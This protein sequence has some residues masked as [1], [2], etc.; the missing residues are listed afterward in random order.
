MDVTVVVVD[1]VGDLGLAS[2]LEVFNT[3]NGLVDDL[4]VDPE[5]WH[6]HTVGVGTSVRSGHGHLVP[7]VPLSRAPTDIG[8]IIL[9][10]VLAAD[11]DAVLDLVDTP[12]NQPVLESISRAAAN[13]SQLSAACT[14][15]FFLAEA[16]ALDGICATTSWWLA[17]AFRR[18]YPKVDLDEGRILC[19]SGHIVTAGAALAHL[20][21]ALSI[22]AT[23]SPAQAERTA[24]ML[25]A[26]S[27]G[28]QRE[29]IVPQVVARGNPLVAAFERWV[30]D[31]IAQQFHIADVARELGVTVRSLQRATHAEIGMSPRDFVNEIRLERAT[32][33][34]RTTTLT[35][36]TVA[37]RVGYLNAGTLRGLYRRRRGRTIAE[38]RSSPLSWEDSATRTRSPATT[39]AAR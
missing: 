34:L 19:R 36:D 2:V 3:A 15:T 29:F 12:A 20:D 1:G 32:R 23:R 24:R 31:H 18:R 7:T 37:A 10:A 28:T 30:R 26:G 9:P 39:T 8:A 4:E 35:I 33:L 17:P 11:A 21:L 38:V 27:G 25:L 13:G 6:V 14:G 22:V 16:G 5:P